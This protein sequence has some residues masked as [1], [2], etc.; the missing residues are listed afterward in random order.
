MRKKITLAIFSIIPLSSFVVLGSS[1]D[2]VGQIMESVR[3][4]AVANAIASFNA[5][6]SGQP[7]IGNEQN[8]QILDVVE[9]SQTPKNVRS[10]EIPEEILWRVILSFPKK[11]ETAAEKARAA[12]Q[13]ETLFTEYFTRQAKL[14][15]ENAEI[16][17]QKAAAYVVDL[18][19]VTERMQAIGDRKKATRERSQKLPN[20]ENY[21]L[22]KELLELQEKQKEIVLKYKEE[23]RKAIDED[24]FAIFEQWLKTEF[25]AKFSS[26]KI[27][28]ND[29]PTKTTPSLNLPNN[30][31]EPIEKSTKEDNQK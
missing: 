8:A 1:P 23:F 7:Q 17:K 14:S 18:S 5:P 12:G 19:P 3:N 4:S 10:I 6:E 31:F 20:E 24:S 26:G 30:G 2:F 27:T 21:A 9:S 29:I 16:F 28:S 13:N 15:V 11:F 25:T 22:K